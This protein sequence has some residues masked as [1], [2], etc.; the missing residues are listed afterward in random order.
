M[1]NLFE[2]NKLPYQFWEYLQ[3]KQL[4]NTSQFFEMLKSIFQNIDYTKLNMVASKS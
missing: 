4:K 1:I 2:D 3:N